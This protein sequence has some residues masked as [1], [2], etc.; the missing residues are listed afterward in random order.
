MLGKMLSTLTLSLVYSASVSA[1]TLEDNLSILAEPLQKSGFTQAALDFSYGDKSLQLTLQPEMP[2][3][4]VGFACI[5]VMPAPIS[6]TLPVLSTGLKAC[7]YRETVA[8]LDRSPVDGPKQTLVIR[9]Y[10]ASQCGQDKQNL[11]T[12]QWTESLQ[13]RG[14]PKPKRSEARFIHQPRLSIDSLRLIPV[15][16]ENYSSAELS[17]QGKKGLVSLTVQA[18]CQPDQKDCVEAPYTIEGLPRAKVRR[19]LC[20]IIRITTSEDQTPVDGFET[21]IEITDNRENQCPTF[22]PLS[23]FEVSLFQRYYSRFEQKEVI[24]TDLFK[25]QA[26]DLK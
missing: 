19:D 4:P 22:A 3:C 17:F 9:D 26:E 18:S 20:G 12:L 7:G 21:R 10:F 25:S 15:S 16:Q 5:Q 6:Y 14:M 1:Q 2:K 24:L 23:S 8:E 11:V 13:S